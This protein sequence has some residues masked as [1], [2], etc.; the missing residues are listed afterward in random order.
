MSTIPVSLDHQQIGS[1][2]L[3]SPPNHLEAHRTAGGFRLH[4]PITVRLGMEKGA[5]TRPLLTNLRANLLY[6]QKSGVLHHLGQAQCNFA[7]TASAPEGPGH[8][9][10]IWVDSPAALAQDKRI[11]S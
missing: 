5:T 1:I 7:S 10:L 6:E 3:E 11:R 8:G 2:T 4:L 9:E